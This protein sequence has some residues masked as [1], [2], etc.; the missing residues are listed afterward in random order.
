ME[1][2]PDTID[3]DDY[4]K[5][6][7]FEARVRQASDFLAEVKAE[8]APPDPNR[9]RSPSLLS[10]K[11]NG[12]LEFRPGE[13]SVYAG[14]NG[15]RKS[16]FT[17]QVALD[18]AVQRQ[19]TLIVSLEMQPA[20]TLARMAR[21]CLADAYPHPRDVE[22]FHRWSDGRLW[23]FDHLGRITPDTALGLLRYFAQQH[24]GQHA[25]LDSMMMICQSEE[26]LDEQKQLTTDLVN[27]A[28]ETGLHIH[29]VA[30][31]RKPQ[32]G[33]ERPPSKYDLRGSAAISDQAHNVLTV[34]ANKAKKAALERNATD[35]AALEQPD[36]LVSCEKQRNGRWEGKLKFWFDESS[37]RFCDDR[38]SRVLPYV[39]QG[40]LA[41]AHLRGGE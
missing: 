33:E 35:E 4:V 41:R 28:K 21:Q 16:M 24:G 40:D 19:R 13:V 17:G 27:V 38:L 10:A 11:A 3:L 26:S 32:T 36:A 14:Y 30:H 25:F 12:R 23:L 5:P 8:L 7:A 29:L 18:L 9:P 39:L 22:A 34:W 1:L 2:I 20:R 6:P 31:C 37:M 15:H